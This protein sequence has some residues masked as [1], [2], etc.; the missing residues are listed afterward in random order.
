M[1][2]ITQSKFIADLHP[3]NKADFLAVGLFEA[4]SEGHTAIVEY[5]CTAGA[6]LNRPHAKSGDTALTIAGFC[7]KDDV[8][9]ALIR[10][11]ADVTLTNNQGINALMIASGRCSASTVS[12]LIEAGQS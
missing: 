5:L 8:V 1:E 6:D 4:A 9:K 11:G 7:G 3:L 12:T 10:A 2:R